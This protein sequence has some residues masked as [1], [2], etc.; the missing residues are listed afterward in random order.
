MVASPKVSLEI[1]VV[2][3]V[4]VQDALLLAEV[5]RIVVLDEVVV[6]L[7]GVVEA[8]LAELAPRMPRLPELGVPLDGNGTRQ[9]V[10]DSGH[11]RGCRGS[12]ECIESVLT[13]AIYANV[14]LWDDIIHTSRH[15]GR[16]RPCL[17]PTRLAPSRRV[18]R[19]HTTFYFIK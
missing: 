1:R 3:V 10:A 5:A 13:L 2:P 19:M 4:L 12:W 11:A 7:S 17:K 14:L 6:Q 8:S 15:T 16:P 18:P 9:G